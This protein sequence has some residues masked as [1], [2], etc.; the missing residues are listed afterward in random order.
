[1]KTMLT[2]SKNDHGWPVIASLLRRFFVN[3]DDNH[4]FFSI[5]FCH[6]VLINQYETE[7]CY[8]TRVNFKTGMTMITYAWITLHKQSI[9]GY[10]LC[11]ENLISAQNF[12]S[13]LCLLSGHL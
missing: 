2:C 8:F 9:H 3:T 10:G 11:C 7:E 5:L 6:Y 13:S 4:D 1:M 12:D